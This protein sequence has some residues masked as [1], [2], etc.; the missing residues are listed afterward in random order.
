MGVLVV[1]VQLGSR[2]DDLVDL[3]APLAGWGCRR[4]GYLRPGGEPIERG[5]SRVRLVASIGSGVYLRFG[6]WTHSPGQDAQGSGS[7]ELPEDEEGTAQSL[8]DIAVYAAQGLERQWS[9]AEWMLLLVSSSFQLV[10]GE[11]CAVVEVGV[12]AGAD[13]EATELLVGHA[14][15]GGEHGDRDAGALSSLA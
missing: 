9:P 3:V 7:S 1:R 13:L 2:S 4:S 14:E 10:E 5:W 15:R 11:C 8:M 6:A 12:G